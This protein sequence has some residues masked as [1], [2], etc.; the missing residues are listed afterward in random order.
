MGLGEK[1]PSQRKGPK[2]LCLNFSLLPPYPCGNGPKNRGS[3]WA[4]CVNCHQSSTQIGL[5]QLDCLIDWHGGLC[6]GVCTS[7]M[8]Y[9]LCCCGG[10]SS[11]AAHE[12]D[13]FPEGGLSQKAHSTSEVLLG[14]KEVWRASVFVNIRYSNP[15]C[16]KVHII[17]LK[18]LKGMGIKIREIF[19]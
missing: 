15:L 7:W 8:P 2:K 12:I 5:P 19:W 3:N 1:L 13:S 17:I 18:I 6:R 14:E 4:F 9:R 16:F 10:V 11:L